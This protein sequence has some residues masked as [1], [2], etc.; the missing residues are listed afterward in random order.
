M[1]RRPPRSTLFPY[2]TLFRS[3]Q[4]SSA[5]EDG[6]SI[7]AQISIWP[8][9]GSSINALYGEQCLGGPGGSLPVALS[10]V[11]SATDPVL[12]AER[13]RGSQRAKKS[14]KLHFG[15]PISISAV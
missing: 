6:K 4:Y 1:I 15:Y 13:K 10:N 9:T 5:L 11:V 7:I 2:T 12:C 3:A 14:E 8:L